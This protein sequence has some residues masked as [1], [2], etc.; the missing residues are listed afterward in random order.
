MKNLI[1]DTTKLRFRY[2]ARAVG[3]AGALLVIASVFLPWSYGH[4]A[5][6]DVGF[7]AAPSPLQLFLIV[8]PVLTLLL[9]ALPLV[10]KRRP[11]SFA[12]AVAWNPSAKTASI[13]TLVTVACLLYTS[14]CV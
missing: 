7:Y 6:D 8:L 11:G 4:G 14:R 13:A 5:L 12:K 2:P 10:G 1:S 9:L 3:I